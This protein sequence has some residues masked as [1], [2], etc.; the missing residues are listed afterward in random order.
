MRLKDE[1]FAVMRKIARLMS[2]ARR[3][4]GVALLSAILFMVLMASM[5][6]VLVSVVL[7]QTV[8]S[9]IAQKR[10]TTIYAAQTGLQSTLALIRAAAAAPDFSGQVYGAS[11]KLPC[12]TTASP[13][14]GNVNG[15]SDG[16]TFSVVITYW[17]GN[18]TNQTSTWLAD[19]ANKVSCTQAAGGTV[20]AF[21]T[22]VSQGKSG[23]VA[24]Q[25]DATVGNR[26]LSAIYQFKVSNV[27]IP[28]GRIYDYNKGYC[29]HAVSAAIGALVTF[30]A[31]ASCTDDTLELWNYATDYKIKLA[32]SLAGNSAGLCITGPVSYGQATQN[33]TLQTCKASTDAAR[34]NQLWSWMGSDTWQGQ[35]STIANG[36]SNYYLGTGYSAGTV[37]TGKYLQVLSGGTNGALAP[38]TQVG[39]GAAGAST[40]QIVNYKEFG[41]CADVT[42]ENI[43]ASYMISYPCKQ[44]PTGTGNYLLWNHKWY[45]DEPTSPATTLGPQQI[46]VNYP[47]DNTTT[48]YC[49]TAPTNGNYPV[50]ATCVAGNV[51]QRWTRSL[52]AS[53]YASSYLFTDNSGRCLTVDPTDLYVGL[54]SKVI[55]TSCNGTDSQKWNA[56]SNT[57]FANIASYKEG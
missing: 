49:L 38:T 56:L 46:Y 42:G 45:Y 16:T 4:E 26:T 52:V 33:A 41:R 21:A 6:L 10:T 13:L 22:I 34:W 43:G 19:S 30:T 28:G 47:H 54:Y 39:A 35:N 17:K 1:R 20:P 36:N 44:D 40:H 51:Q 12:A 25:S 48:K 18:P 53:T 2:P 31:A 37:L 11:S 27:N 29:M 5:S 15:Q 3:E 23:A 14:V 7:S 8:P 32:S 55:V 50:F 9:S 24:R 57:P